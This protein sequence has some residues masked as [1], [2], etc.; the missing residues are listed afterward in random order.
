MRYLPQ[1]YSKT[2]LAEALSPMAEDDQATL[3][4][5]VLE[6]RRKKQSL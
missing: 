3:L 1:N 2:Q 4:Q 6:R 5:Y